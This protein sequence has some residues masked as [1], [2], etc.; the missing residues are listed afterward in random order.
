MRLKRKSLGQSVRGFFIVSI[1]DQW[2][3]Y[4]TLG[5]DTAFETVAVSIAAI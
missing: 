1:H 5:L 4:E 2:A 3:R